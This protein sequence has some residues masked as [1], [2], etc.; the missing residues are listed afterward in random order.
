MKKLLRA[1]GVLAFASIIAATAVLAWGRTGISPLDG[2]FEIIG[3]LF[4]IQAL[5]NSYVQEGF[6]KLMLFVVVFAVSNMI[7]TKV[8]TKGNNPQGKKVAGI[9]SFA[10][11]MIGIFLMPTAWLNVTGGVVVAVMSSLIFLLIFYGGMYVA[12]AYLKPADEGT[13]PKNQLKAPG[14]FLN[15]LGILLLF[16]LLGLLSIWQDFAQVP[17]F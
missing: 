1:I 6:L 15:L 5:K 3:R 2:A 9:V 13:D 8:F 17:I 16:F 14:W 12:M 7:L 10:F 11:S 4:N